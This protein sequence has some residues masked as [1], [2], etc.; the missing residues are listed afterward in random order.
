[1][2]DKQGESPL[3]ALGWEKWVGRK[4]PR[5]WRKKVYG[6][7]VHTTGASLPAK[8]KDAGQEPIDRA[9]KHYLSSQGT[10][11]VADYT[12]MIVQGANEEMQANGVGMGLQ[13]ASVKTGNWVSQSLAN[14]VARAKWVGRWTSPTVENPTDLYPSKLANSCY[15]HVEMP[16][17][18]FWYNAQLFEQAPPMRAGLRFTKAQHDAIVSLSLD[19]A[20]RN[21][22]PDGWWKRG[23]LLGHEDLSPISRSTSDG[24]W[25]PGALRNDPWFDWLYVKSE[26]ERVLAHRQATADELDR[27]TEEVRVIP[28]PPA[29]ENVIK[30]F[31]AWLTKAFTRKDS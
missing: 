20:D 23:R 16:P 4:R 5:G 18:V 11:Y 24:C 3:A 1:M 12:G 6:L 31:T 30:A 9:H 8:A 10:H 21:K 14:T 7:V 22:W 26:I 28:N 19:V 2:S 15:V 29:F 17:C 13:I 25:D 27:L